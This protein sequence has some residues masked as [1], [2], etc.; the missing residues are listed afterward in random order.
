MLMLCSATTTL[1]VLFEEPPKW[2]PIT[3]N[4]VGQQIGL[5]EEWFRSRLHKNNDQPLV[6]DEDLPSKQRFPKPRLP[7]SGKISSPRK[8]PIKEQQ[9]SAK[10]KR[11][12]EDTNGN[13]PQVNG[14][15][16]GEGNQASSGNKGPGR[17]I[18]KLKLEMPGSKDASADADKDAEKES[19]SAVGMMSPESIG[20]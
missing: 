19:G 12:V 6:E 15:I 11:K 10:K 14:V 3:L 17:P 8:R 18:G 5:V 20:A 7:P 16:N 2:A 9:A 1:G 4:N 13:G